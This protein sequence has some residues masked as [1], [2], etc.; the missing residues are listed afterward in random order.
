MGAPL[1]GNCL[2]KVA[3]RVVSHVGKIVCFRRNWAKGEKHP[4]KNGP[5]FFVPAP[6]HPWPGDPI[7]KNVKDDFS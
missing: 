5:S 4:G 7:E 3:Y 6:S 2:F 1:A